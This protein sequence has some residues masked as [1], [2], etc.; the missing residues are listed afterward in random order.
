MFSNL[1]F[2]SIFVCFLIFVL[3]L[4]YE[5]RKTSRREQ[6]KSDSFWA[7]EDEANR[8]RKKDISHLPFFK[9][10]K[11][12]IPF[13]E[14]EDENIIFY[15]N[16]VLHYLDTPM[17]NLSGYT[18]TDLKLAY[19]VGNFKTLSEYDENFN[20]LFMNLSHLGKSYQRR[21]LLSE[22]ELVY[23]FC[24]D[25]GFQKATDY[26]ALAAVYK[27]QGTPRKISDLISRAE[28]S[29]LPYKETLVQSLKETM[30]SLT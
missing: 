24:L 13:P 27:E 11:N 19:G 12:R 8:T 29:G 23:Q 3:W 30:D 14:T 28:K 1:P 5:R 9:P 22:A 15:Q 7:R 4:N 26:K 25:F 18:N 10:D 2:P 17:M 16:E 6:K 20:S 21:G